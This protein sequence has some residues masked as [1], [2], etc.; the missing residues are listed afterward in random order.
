MYLNCHSYFSFRYGTMSPGELV[1]RAAALGIGALA[2][3]DVNSTSGV[4]GFVAACREKGIHPVVGI[5]FRDERKQRLEF[6]GLARNQEGFR[7]LNELLSSRHPSG[8]QH[9]HRTRDNCPNVSF[10]LPYQPQGRLYFPQE[11]DCIGV[12]LRDLYR[13]KQ[14]HRGLLAEKMVLLQPV[15]F[16]SWDDFFTHQVLRAIDNNVAVSQLQRGHFADPGHCFRDPDSLKRAFSAFPQLAANAEN[17]LGQCQFDLGFPRNHN[18]QSFTGSAY[19]DKLL[20]EKLAMDGFRYRYAPDDQRALERLQKELAAIDHLGFNAYFLITWDIVRYA[21]NR[22]FVHVGR[23]SGANSLVAY[24]LKITDVDPIELDLYFERFINHKRSSPPD[25]DIDFSWRERDEV[26]DYVFKR[27]GMRHTALLASYNTFGGRSVLRAL[28]KAFGLGKEAT[29]R[30]VHLPDDPGQPAEVCQEIAKYQQRLDGFPNHLSI[31]AG[32]MLISERPITYFTALHLPPKNF[33][34]THFDMYAAEEIGLHKFDILSQRGLGHIMD[35]VGIVRA[36]R[37]VHLDIH[38]VGKF[39]KD[40]KVAGLLKEGKTIGC[41]YVES[42][43]MRGLLSKLKCSTYLDV[44]AASSIIRPGVAKSGMMREYIQRF[45]QP[46]SFQY[47]H[48]VMEKLLKETYGIM[49][50]QED[51]IKVA[52][53]FAGLDLTDAD[54]LRRAMSGKTRGQHEM[55]RIRQRFFDNCHQKGYDEGVTAEV[56]RQ[57]ESFSGYSFSKAHSASYAVESFQSLYLKAHFPLEFMVAVINN[58]GGFYRTEFYVHEARM[59]GASVHPPCVNRSEYLTTIR[60]KDIYLGFVHLRHGEKPSL[61][62]IV[63]ERWKNGEYTS[64]ADLMAR[65]PL[66]FGQLALLVRV[67]ALAFTGLS[68]DMLLQEARRI[69]RQQA[70]PQRSRLF[71]E[72]GFLT[73]PPP[74]AVD[75]LADA[76]DQLDLLGFPLCS[77]F[78]LLKTSF[79]GELGAAQ[80]MRHIGQTVRMMGYLVC[81]KRVATSQRHTMYFGTWLDADGHFF[82]TVHFPDSL[83]GYPFTGSGIYLLKGKVVEDFGFPS[84]EVAKMAKMG[85]RE[86]P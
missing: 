6:I 27:Y 45:H 5:E 20:L 75:S 62:Q 18:R 41:F 26:I 52:H 10:I 71:G 4:F 11:N 77:P 83:E 74:G 24:C 44:V 80:L 79:R 66:P 84:L 69:A 51:V 50:Y 43:A 15:T 76:Y 3:T 46:H 31:H 8:L 53:H 86:R 7:E 47:L 35:A 17:L 16:R 55:E 32:G 81:R 19:D 85:L 60:G 14:A 64:L 1:D 70:A 40:A 29:D 23:G 57:I 34:T 30:L 58:F 42:S 38:R 68:K 28:G 25:F 72:V 48:P 56:W 73:L 37:E 22:G 59:A 13:I 33:H 2:L 21:E 65:V 12:T 61:W 78:D 54:V 9:F 36:N 49:I 39:K 82:D 63:K 67:G